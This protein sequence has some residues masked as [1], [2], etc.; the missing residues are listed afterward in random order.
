MTSRVPLSSWPRRAPL[1]LNHIDALKNELQFKVCRLIRGALPL[2]N[3]QVSSNIRV[4]AATESDLRELME[5][6]RVQNGP[7]TTRSTS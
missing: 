7:C 5:E 1:F 2:G 4:I 6:G 3:R